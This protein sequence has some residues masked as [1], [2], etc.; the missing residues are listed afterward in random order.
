MHLEMGDFDAV[1]Q[2]CT[3]LF[4]YWDDEQQNHLQAIFRE[5]AKKQKC[6]VKFTHRIPLQHKSLEAR[7]DDVHKFRRQHEQLSG[8]IARFVATKGLVTT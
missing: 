3:K 8:V 5:M 2:A 7:L 6:E 1:M 4:T